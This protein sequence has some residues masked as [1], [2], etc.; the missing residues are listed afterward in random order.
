MIKKAEYRTYIL[1]CRMRYYRVLL[2]FGMITFTVG[3]DES[4]FRPAKNCA[5]IGCFI[6]YRT[7]ASERHH[8]RWQQCFEPV[9]R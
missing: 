5:N 3:F 2:I 9:A 6:E 7:K 1:R 8:D 4:G